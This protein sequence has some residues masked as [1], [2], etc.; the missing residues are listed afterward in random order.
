MLTIWVYI[1][2]GFKKKSMS[3]YNRL[4]PDLIEGLEEKMY[5]N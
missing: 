5:S 3:M 1:N 2:P 4:A